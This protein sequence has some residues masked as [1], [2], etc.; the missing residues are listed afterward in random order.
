M[1]MGISNV[2]F[3]SFIFPLILNNNVALKEMNDEG[4]V[5]EGL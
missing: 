4:A 1:I 2:G 5:V 3:K